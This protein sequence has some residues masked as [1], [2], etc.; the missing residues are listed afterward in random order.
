[1]ETERERETDGQRHGRERCVEVETERKER[2]GRDV[3][4]KNIEANSLLTPSQPGRSCQPEK[5]KHRERE[6]DR[7]TD[8]QRLRD[9]ERQRERERERDRERQ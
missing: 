5:N 7:Q 8:R 6:G 3:A 1:M 9:R 2:R 4:I